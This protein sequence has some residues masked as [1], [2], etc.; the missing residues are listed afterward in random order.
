MGNLVI[1]C[2][3]VFKVEKQPETDFLCYLSLYIALLISL[4]LHEYFQYSIGVLWEADIQVI[5]KQ[6]SLW[7]LKLPISPPIR[8]VDIKMFTK[9]SCFVV[10][11][12]LYDCNTN[13]FLHCSDMF[14]NAIH[15]ISSFLEHIFR[16]H[17]FSY[18]PKAH[19]NNCL[20]MK[21]ETRS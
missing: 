18:E 13:N 16:N 1:S 6:F 8:K 2:N 21:P 3:N 7:S 19:F 11:I 4:Y 12:A 14:C 20:I 17:P 5:R 9:C 10:Y 15:Y